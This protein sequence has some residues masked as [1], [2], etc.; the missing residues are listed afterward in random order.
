MNREDRR[1]IGR[2]ILESCDGVSLSSDKR[3]RRRQH[4]TMAQQ[5][6]NSGTFLN[7]KAP[8]GSIPWLVA[9]WH[10]HQARGHKR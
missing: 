1:A 6:I 4:R 8:V 2:G 3:K 10:R 5:L 7:G 9:Q